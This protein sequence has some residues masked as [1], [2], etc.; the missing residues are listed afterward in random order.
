LVA[1]AAA[2]V[3]LL[4]LQ[5]R[6]LADTS[7][8]WCPRGIATAVDPHSPCLLIAAK[9]GAGIDAATLAEKYRWGMHICFPPSRRA[10]WCG[11]WHEPTDPADFL[12]V[13]GDGADG[14]RAAD[15]RAG[16]AIVPNG[17]NRHPILSTLRLPSRDFPL[18]AM[19][20]IEQVAEGILVPGLFG[21]D[22][23]DVGVV[24]GRR[25]D[26]GF[27]YVASSNGLVD[28]GTRA[29]A[30]ARAWLPHASEA[31]VRFT[32]PPTIT[33]EEIGHSTDAI[34]AVNKNMDLVLCAT[35]IPDID[36]SIFAILG[37]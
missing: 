32:G 4:A 17:A 18:W 2:G 27:S 21:L 3:S 12:F 26:L 16:M 11:Y 9:P 34:E 33:F 8:P 25:R 29:V 19:R 6:V 28:P 7:R 22:L 24:V 5:R 37:G 23:V 31:V 30:M 10:C 13:V 14:L 36:R 15:D 1:G 20:A 35:V